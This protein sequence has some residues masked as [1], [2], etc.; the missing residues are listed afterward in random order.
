VV[1]INVC[2]PICAA[3]DRHQ[4]PYLASDLLWSGLFG[5]AS[6]NTLTFPAIGVAHSLDNLTDFS[7]AAVHRLAES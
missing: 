1:S 5:L 2:R 7:L 6:L 4:F 3:L